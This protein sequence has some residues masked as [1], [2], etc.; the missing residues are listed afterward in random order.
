VPKGENVLST[1]EA[2]AISMKT[3]G[4]GRSSTIST[5]ISNAP[6]ETRRPDQPFR[7]TH[8]IGH[9][10]LQV[11]GCSDWRL[12]SL[13]V[14]FRI[15]DPQC[16]V[17]NGYSVERCELDAASFAQLEPKSFTNFHH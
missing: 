12:A 10:D 7:K 16:R 17:F 13:G 14:R 6:K 1:R 15:L 2:S 11:A 3:E 4:G 5:N 9:H 8:R